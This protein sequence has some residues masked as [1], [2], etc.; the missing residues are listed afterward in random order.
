MASESEQS[1]AGRSS[2]GNTLPTLYTVE[3][4]AAALGIK[5]STL[6]QKCRER[7]VPHVRFARRYRFTQ[8]QYEQIVE[9]A[10]VQPLPLMT[11]QAARAARRQVAFPG[12]KKP[13]KR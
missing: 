9:G 4:V 1:G 11:S 13:A 7:D 10:T 5:P 3:E 6:W 12:G 2:G 8:E